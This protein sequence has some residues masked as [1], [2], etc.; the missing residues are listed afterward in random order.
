MNQFPVLNIESIRIVPFQRHHLTSRY[1][2]WL[3]DPDVVQFSE[4][5]HYNHTMFTCE[6]YFDSMQQANGY[7]LAIETSMNGLGHI[8]NIGVSIDF[9][10]QIA[11]MS[12]LVGEKRAWGT[13]LASVAWN[14]VLMEML[15]NQGMR[16]VTAGTMSVNEPMLRLMK[17]SGMQIESRLLR[18]FFWKGKEV[19]LVQAGIFSANK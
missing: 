10:N 12:I 7:F 18:H 14:A 17:R 19:D 3:N 4:Q 9:H 2:S 16:K 6:Q 1:V 11:D 15:K 13:G 5:R 8:G